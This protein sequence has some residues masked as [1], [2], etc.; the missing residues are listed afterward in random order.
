MFAGVKKTAGA[1]AQPGWLTG[2]I[3][4]K[5]LRVS[6]RRR[7]N[8]WLRVVYILLLTV[9][10]GVVWLSVVDYRGS[11]AY[12][13]SRM[14]V[15]GKQI[16]MTVVIFQF[17]ATQILAVVMLSTAISDE[18]Y[19]RTLGLLMTTP[20]NS[21][22]IV[23]GKVLSKLLQLLLLLAITLPILSLV[24]I[25]GGVSWSYLLSSVCITLTA[26]LLAGSLSLF[27]S[28][29]NRRAYGVIIRT[30]FILGCFYFMLPMAVMAVVFMPG[31][32][33][34]ASPPP[35]W[36]VL[37]AALYHTNPVYAISRTT[38]QMLSPGPAGGYLWPVHCLVM[39]MLSALVLGWAL[40]VVRAVALRQA[41]GQLDLPDNGR[42]RR[43][44]GRRG[45]GAKAERTATGP[46]KRVVGPA[47][48][49]KELRAP[50][51]KGVDNRNSYIGL[52][53][54]ILALAFTYWTSARGKSLDEAF[55]H[56][57]YGLLFV[58]MGIIF[59]VIFSATRITSER[60]SQTWPLLLATPLG[61]RDIL[62]GKAVSAFRRCLPI[63]GLLAAHMVLFTLAGYIHPAASVHLLVVVAWVTCFTIAAGLYFSARFTRTTSSVVA[64]FG[65]ILGLWVLGPTIAGMLSA[66][67]GSIDPLRNYMWF[68][69]A[70]QT[71][72]LMSGASGVRNA[73]LSWRALRYGEEQVIFDLIGGSFG[74][75]RMTLMLIGTALVYMVAA[76]FFFWRAKCR[77]RR[78]VF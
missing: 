74:F 37:E 75:A 28:I 43:R 38:E 24:R 72:L 57:S 1:I 13:Q 60:E 49:W 44:W 76:A 27:I 4:G 42:R 9:F 26:V 41:T 10:V 69:P 78:S 65:L 19:H 55:S 25:L 8:Y 30:I 73:E 22:Q 54:A 62:L 11:A 52:A 48:V 77:L 18:V 32:G 6:S 58:S 40:K 23:M 31:L 16:V 63:W 50:F 15:A 66:F 39:V 17:A 68:H 56:A 20:I 45:S 29:Q 35:G 33:T 67:G 53:M 71:E 36:K 3:F 21:L 2:P 5:E 14:A 64:S 70:I 51:I 46:I 7:R 34:R 12:Q 61:D 59:A 47:V